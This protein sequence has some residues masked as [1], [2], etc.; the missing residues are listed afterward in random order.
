MNVVP[1]PDRVDRFLQR[2]DAALATLPESERRPW[3]IKVI[4]GLNWRYA[5][6][7]C[8]EGESE[9]A[10]SVDDPPHCTDFLLMICGAS[11]RLHNGGK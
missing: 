6:F 11:Q 7:L 5:R 10:Y 3:L 9:P 4:D 8:T 1:L 2:L